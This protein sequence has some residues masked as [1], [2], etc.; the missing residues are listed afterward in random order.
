VQTL[1]YG[2]KRP[3]N[4]D[5]G[6]VFFDAL[7]DNV[8]KDDAHTHNGVDSPSLVV[9]KLAKFVVA[10]PSTGWTLDTD[11]TYYQTVT[12]AGSFVWGL[13]V[14]QAFGSGGTL[15]LQPIAAKYVKDTAT[16]FRVYL[17]VNNQGLNLLFT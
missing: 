13:V 12:M 10:V 14:I 17:L 2:R 1:T 7:R 4:L 6:S 8:T 9:D 16:T 5:R 3:D 11:G 15:A